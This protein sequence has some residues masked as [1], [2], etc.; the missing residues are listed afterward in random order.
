MSI[1]DDIEIRSGKSYQ[2]VQHGPHYTVKGFTTD[3]LDTKKIEDASNDF[4]AIFI[5]LR[6]ML[7]KHED[8]ADKTFDTKLNICQKL[9]RKLSWHFKRR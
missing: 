9:A 5:N 1:P 7:M 6:E 2:W 8:L 4:E 3:N